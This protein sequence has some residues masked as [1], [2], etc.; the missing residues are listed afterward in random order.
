MKDEHA[1]VMR[2]IGPLIIN[3]ARASGQAPIKFKL[4]T[5]SLIISHTH[6]LGSIRM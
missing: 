6:M 5:V 4:H 3:L 2:R 1:R